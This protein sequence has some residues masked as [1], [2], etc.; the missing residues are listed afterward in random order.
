MR[1]D[2]CSAGE[3]IFII[4]MNKFGERAFKTYPH[5]VEAATVHIEYLKMLEENENG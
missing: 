2:D 5:N 1:I 4:E 3:P